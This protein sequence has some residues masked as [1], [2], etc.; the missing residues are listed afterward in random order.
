MP[1]EGLIVAWDQLS[2]GPWIDFDDLD[3]WNHIRQEFTRSLDPEVCYGG[4]E[5]D[6]EEEYDLIPDADLILD[7]DSVF[8]WM[9]SGLP[10]QLLLVWLARFFECVGADVRRFRVVQFSQLH[11]VVYEVFS[12]QTLNPETVRKHGVPRSLTRVE[13]DYLAEVWDA[14]VSEVPLPMLRILAETGKTPLPRLKR[15]LRS[16]LGR[17]PDSDSGLPQW[18]R[19]LL[20]HVRDDGPSAVRVICA[21]IIKGFTTPDQISDVYLYH[22]L[23]RMG[24]ATLNRKL[25]EL[26]GPSRAMRDT[27]VR[28]TETGMDVLNGKANAVE[29]NGIDDWV[30]GVHLNST[31]DD[32]WFCDGET[33]MGPGV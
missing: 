24:D 15:S 27:Q 12:V 18:D 32:A 5:R 14:L 30:C 25:V 31:T 20:K 11:D 6:D 23:R 13:L 4:P 22:R 26:S 28:I 9:G 16:M 10:D 17:Y 2:C 21:A 29:I 1:Q 33:L 3:E 8:L 7:A 19:V